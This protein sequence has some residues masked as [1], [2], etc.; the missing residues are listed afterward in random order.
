MDWFSHLMDF[1]DFEDDF[2]SKEETLTDDEKEEFNY[3]WDFQPNQAATSQN[4]SPNLTTTDTH[5]I[6]LQPSCRIAL[7]ESMPASCSKFSVDGK[8]LA[9]GTRAGFVQIH[10]VED[11]R[12]AFTLDLFQPG[13]KKRWPCTALGIRPCQPGDSSYNVLLSCDLN[14]QI[15]YWHMT[16]GMHLGISKEPNNS[17]YAIDFHPTGAR[18]ATGGHDF[19]VRIYDAITRSITQTLEEGNGWDTAG[20]S[21]RVF[22]VKWHPKHIHVALSGGWD[23][24][25]QVWDTR[26]HHS[27]QSIYGPF[28]CGDALDMNEAGDLVLTGSWRANQ[29]LQEWDF[30]S[31]RLVQDIPL[32]QNGE[33]SCRLYC[34]KYGKGMSQK[35]IAAA[36]SGSNEKYLLS[37]TTNK[38]VAG[39]PQV[40]KATHGLSFASTGSL[41]AVT[42]HDFVDVF[43]MDALV[44]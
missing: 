3:D 36:G 10:D 33:E 22:A 4:T 15:H 6:Q 9:I 31:G 1:E 16:S 8:W 37:T 26:A 27:V 39:L 24:T 42:N 44:L 23:S 41:L 18:F 32:Q 7:G 13:L 30:G 35:L 12:L 38:I 25:V 17:V 43:R 29:Q 20:H 14:G 19:K 40:D 34:A 21:N 11:G 5:R 2:L 28:I